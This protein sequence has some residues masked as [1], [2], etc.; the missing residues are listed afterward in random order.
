MPMHVL[1]QNLGWPPRIALL[2]AGPGSPALI[3]LLVPG[4]L[5]VQNEGCQG[6][7]PR[8]GFFLFGNQK[9]LPASYLR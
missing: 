5:G 2:A 7:E 8:T 4:P 6:M 1:C 9:L 3:R